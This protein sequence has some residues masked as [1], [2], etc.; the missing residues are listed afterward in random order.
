MRRAAKIDANQNAIVDQLRGIPNLS[1]AITSKLGAGFP[2]LVIG[3]KGI[4]YL[5]ELKDGKKPPS[6]QKLTLPEQF[7]HTLWKGQ[8]STCAN[9]TEI[10]A[11]LKIK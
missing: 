2:D 8:I 11:V 10:L 5:I 6:A 3:Y 9:L 1:V 4:N 7:F